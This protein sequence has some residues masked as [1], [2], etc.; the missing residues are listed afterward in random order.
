MNQK[1]NQAGNGIQRKVPFYIYKKDWKVPDGYKDVDIKNVTI[2][3]PGEHMSEN[4]TNEY[5]DKLCTT[6][7]SEKEHDMIQI[8]NVKA[9]RLRLDTELE[10]LSDFTSGRE[11]SLVKTKL[12][13]AMMWLGME[14]KRLGQKYP[15][16]VKPPYPSSKDPETGNRIEPTAEGLTFGECPPGVPTPDQDGDT[17]KC[18]E[19]CDVPS[20][21]PAPE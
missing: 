15:D 12:Q 13:E 17:K 8:R 5:Q 7:T 18:P 16:V 2:T 9:M 3:K 4:Q 19:K 11:T 14:L 6:G 21:V 1:G 20:D 10:C